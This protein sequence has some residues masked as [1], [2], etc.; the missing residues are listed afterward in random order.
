MIFG[1]PFLLNKGG[2]AG[3]NEFLLVYGYKKAFDLGRYGF[4]AAFMVIVFCLLV[5][6]VVLFSRATKLTEAEL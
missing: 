4:A 3:S 2:P 6:L 5:V 1:V